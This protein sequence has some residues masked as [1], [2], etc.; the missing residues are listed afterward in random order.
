MALSREALLAAAKCPTETV[1]VPE[2]GSAIT[3][4]GMTGRELIMFQ[5]SVDKAKKTGEAA[6]DEESFLAKLLVR[7]IVDDDGSRLLEDDDWQAV[8]EWPGVM[9]QRLTSVA[10]RL[11]GYGTDEGNS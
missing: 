7:C 11:C 9:V 10:L 1:E 2:L 4:R 6:I 5:R 8:L 3:L